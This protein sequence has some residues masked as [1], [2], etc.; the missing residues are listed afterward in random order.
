[1]MC[2]LTGCRCV[3]ACLCVCVYMLLSCLSVYCSAAWSHV[4]C[5]SIHVCCARPLPP[6][7][8]A[9]RPQLHALEQRYHRS[10]SAAQGDHDS[11]DNHGHSGHGVNFG[12]LRDEALTAAEQRLQL[13]SAD[14]ADKQAAIQQHIAEAAERMDA[15]QACG[16]GACA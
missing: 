4:V 6:S 5:V 7:L 14:I 13:L 3:S 2:A 8:T 10:A 1:M 12:M 16:T 9:D 11:F 15:L